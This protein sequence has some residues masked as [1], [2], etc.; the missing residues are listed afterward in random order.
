MERPSGN[1]EESK[2]A[3]EKWYDSMESPAELTI[4]GKHG[5]PAVVFLAQKPNVG[6]L[7]R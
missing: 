2:Q 6:I 7:P 4:K 3:R 1:D 5:N